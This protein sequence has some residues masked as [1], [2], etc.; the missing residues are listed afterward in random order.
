[1]F[2]GLG[3]HG[4]PYLQTGFPDCGR[5]ISLFAVGSLEQGSGIKSDAQKDTRPAFALQTHSE[6]EK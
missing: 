1:L 4:K 5:E 3:Y 2:G 6:G